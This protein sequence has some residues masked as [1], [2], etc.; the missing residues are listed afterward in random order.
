VGYLS[1]PF[2][3]TVEP[4]AVLGV[5][6]E[7]TFPPSVSIAQYDFWDPRAEQRVSAPAVLTD[8]IRV[9]DTTSTLR[10]RFY[11]LEERQYVIHQGP[12]V[13]VRAPQ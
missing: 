7:Q 1:E 11:V 10:P 3:Q 9:P 5:S 6:I 13:T 2:P 8:S 4:G 12:E